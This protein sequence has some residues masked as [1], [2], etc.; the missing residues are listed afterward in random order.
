MKPSRYLPQN[1]PAEMLRLGELAEAAAGRIICACVPAFGYTPPDDVLRELV[2]LPA[3]L[4]DLPHRHAMVLGLLRRHGALT[5]Y[6][7]IQRLKTFGV[8][9]LRDGYGVWLVEC[10]R[11]MSPNIAA[12]IRPIADFQKYCRRLRLCREQYRRALLNL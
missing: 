10:L 3:D 11:E 6:E 5:P 12:D 7:I 2:R 8:D 4:G 1:V 9:V